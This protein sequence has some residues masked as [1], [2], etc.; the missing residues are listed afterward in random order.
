MLDFDESLSQDSPIE[1]NAVKCHRR[2]PFTDVTPSNHIVGGIRF[3]TEA[4]SSSPV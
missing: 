2:D 1:F 4:P 3:T